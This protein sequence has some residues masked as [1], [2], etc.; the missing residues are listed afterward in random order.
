MAT[1]RLALARA[2]AAKPSVLVLDDPLSA[3]DV[4]TEALVEEARANRKKAGHI[5]G[6]FCITL[7]WQRAHVAYL[8][9]AFLLLVTIGAAT[10]S[11]AA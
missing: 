9:E 8:D 7:P 1:S 2:V 6:L 3:L 10:A 11:L 5:P 4:N